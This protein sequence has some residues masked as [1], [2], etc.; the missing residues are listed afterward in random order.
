MSYNGETKLYI[1]DDSVE[2]FTKK[3]VLTFYDNPFIELME[4]YAEGQSNVNLYNSIWSFDAL[5]ERY[6]SRKVVMPLWSCQEDLMTQIDA[7]DFDEYVYV[8]DALW[9]KPAA[10]GYDRNSFVLADLDMEVTKRWHDLSFSGKDIVYTP[11]YIKT[12]VE[13]EVITFAFETAENTAC[14]IDR[15]NFRAN[16]P[17]SYQIHADL[18]FITRQ[19][20][21]EAWCSIKDFSDECE[22]PGF[23][24]G[25]HIAMLNY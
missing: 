11:D 4:D 16:Y 5:K 3:K 15:Y 20:D 1:R 23:I 13:V 24:E 2:P 8:G 12:D 21:Y 22:L 14:R 25:K 9:A 18:A 17:R 6:G 10:F 19:D 7:K